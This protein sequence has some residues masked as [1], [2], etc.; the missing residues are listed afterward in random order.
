MSEHKARSE[1]RQL[2]QPALRRSERRRG[3]LAL[4]LIA[5]LAIFMI[6]C[7]FVPI[8]VLLARGVHRRGSAR[9]LARDRGG[10]ARMARLRSAGS[11]D[12][13]DVCRGAGRVTTRRHAA[14]GGEST[15]LRAAR[16]AHT[17]DTHRGS[18][19]VGDNANRRSMPWRQSTCAGASARPGPPCA[20]LPG[21][22]RPSTSWRQS[23]CTWMPSTGCASRRPIAA[24]SS[25]Y[26][27]ARSGSAPWLR[28][29]VRCSAIRSLT[30][31]SSLPS[32]SRASVARAGSA[33]VLDLGARQ[34]DSV[35][36]VAAGPGPG[37]Q[38]CS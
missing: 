21:R 20:K 16:L 33:A 4:A 7:F 23:I 25:M 29:C 18:V 8:G 24:C 36:G 12:R 31:L 10:V 32:E 19:A 13:S 3:L 2:L 15:Q 11:F 26:S 14:R 5:P 38:H 22:S 35:D 9:G 30:C 1:E 37:E 6:A 34:D 27:C 28:R 17:A